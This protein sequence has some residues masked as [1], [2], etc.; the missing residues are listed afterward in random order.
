MSTV[1]ATL[2]FVSAV[3]GWCGILLNNRAF[4]TAWNVLLWISFIFLVAPG[5]QAYKKHTFNLEGKT[6]ELWS[7]SLNVHQRRVVQN[8]LSCCG[9]YNPAIEAA[10]SSRCYA[11][12]SLGGCKGRFLRFERMMFRY[13]YTASFALVGPHLCLIVLGI[14]CSNHVTYR[15]GKGITPPP[16]QLDSTTTRTIQSDFLMQLSSLYGPDLVRQ[17]LECQRGRSHGGVRPSGGLVSVPREGFLPDGFQPP[18]SM[19]MSN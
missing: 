17:V 15:F 12:S 9:Y 3:V 16:Y 19:R 18:S 6:N 2:F 13:L 4:L 1:A 5:Y 7:R 11:R 8:T 14:L 10:Q